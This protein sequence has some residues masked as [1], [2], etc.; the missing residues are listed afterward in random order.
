M[1]Y[2]SSFRFIDAQTESYS[3]A[4]TAEA[5]TINAASHN[6]LVAL[7]LLLYFPCFPIAMD[8]FLVAIDDVGM[9][10]TG[11]EQGYMVSVHQCGFYVDLIGAC[12]LIDPFDASLRP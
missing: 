8:G 4:Y 9:V 7:V 11:L 10:D 2:I 12:T 3:R 6:H 1:K 5:N